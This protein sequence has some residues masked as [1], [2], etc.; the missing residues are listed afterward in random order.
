MLAATIL[1]VAYS[2]PTLAPRPVVNR[3]A[4]PLMA[5]KVTRDSTLPNTASHTPELWSDRQAASARHCSDRECLA[6]TT[7][8]RVP[9]SPRPQLIKT[10]F[11]AFGERQQQKAVKK[12][13]KILTRVEELKV[14]STLAEAGLLSGAEQAGVFSKLEKAGTFSFAEKLLPLV[15]NL[16]LLS[17]AEALIQL[18]AGGI[19]GL[20]VILLAG[21]TRKRSPATEGP[22][23][24]HLRLCPRSSAH[25]PLSSARRGWA[26][27]CAPRR[28]GRPRR[29]ADRQRGPCRRGV[30]RAA[31]RRLPLRAAPGQELMPTLFGRTEAM[32]PRTAGHLGSDQGGER[33]T[34]RRRAGRTQ[35]CLNYSTWGLSGQRV[36]EGCRHVH[37]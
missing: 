6:L 3:A 29:A 16:K 35:Q 10:Q 4:S 34:G 33:V 28:P 7:R 32:R 11:D 13:V 37:E 30:G 18:P 5:S 27:L 21:G 9:R 1:A 12:P 23:R 17:T 15:D 25:R 26:D 20:A 31:R 36:R 24:H 2:A 8:L 22:R 19:L 14:L